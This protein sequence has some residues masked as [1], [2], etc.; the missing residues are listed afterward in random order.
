VFLVRD[1]KIAMVTGPVPHPW[2]IHHQ[3]ST[4]LKVLP[5]GTLYT[6]AERG[7]HNGTN[8]KVN[9]KFDYY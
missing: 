4:T 6:R 7:K 2:D 1:T 8:Q 3:L 9:F 5:V